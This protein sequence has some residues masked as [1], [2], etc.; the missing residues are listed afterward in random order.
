MLN[1]GASRME[2]CFPAESFPLH[3]H[4]L[5]PLADVHDPIHVRV[6]AIECNGLRLMFIGSAFRWEGFQAEL[7]EKL[8]QYGFRPEDVIVFRTG[9][10]CVPMIR[11]HEHKIP[12]HYAAEA[13]AN[14]IC[15]RNAFLQAV[16]EA[17]GNMR[18]AVYGIG[19][20]KCFV[21]CERCYTT[22]NGFGHEVC[23]P[24]VPIDRTMQILYFQDLEG[25]P[26]AGVLNY[27]VLASSLMLA[28]DVD[29]LQ[30]ITDDL[31]GFACG[32]VERR[33]GA[34][35]VLAW[36][37]GGS[38]NCWMAHNSVLYDDNG[39]PY[40][41][42]YVNG[43][44][45]QIVEA[46]AQECA[47]VA[48]RILRKTECIRDRIS[49][50]SAKTRVWIPGQEIIPGLRGALNVVI[51]HLNGIYPGDD[52]VRVR[53]II[54][55]NG[56]TCPLLPGE[57]YPPKLIIP[58]PTGENIPV[59]IRMFMLDDIC[60]YIPEGHYFTGTE[61]KCKDA[62]KAPHLMFLLAT[63]LADSFTNHGYIYIL[64]DQHK[65][66]QSFERVH[67]KAYPG[68]TDNAIVSGML[69]LF[70]ELGVTGDDGRVVYY[71]E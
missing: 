1:V 37:D 28:K 17:C 60:L 25:T 12:D 22:E 53:D 69:T 66:I 11:D 6:V 14:T 40:D 67:S 68:K 30:K 27:D 9:S 35:F 23:M 19:S 50:S 16:D 61:R 64:D 44:L 46:Q 4:T 34:D 39:L 63:V 3:T 41:F 5:R 49:I 43:A 2:I 24:G 36:T 42:E 59:D 52:H 20:D 18:Q 56:G 62:S 57:E 33:M 29:G 31:P 10:H 21:N 15:V 51:A 48:L 70:Q 26:I 54:E 13:D 65:D 38:G 7:E 58:K 32:Y 47:M 8:A 45:F 55:R 71:Y